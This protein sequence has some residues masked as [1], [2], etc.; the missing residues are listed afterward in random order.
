MLLMVCHHVG[1]IHLVNMVT[2]EDD[3]IIGVIAVDK[4]DILVNSIG[5]TLVPAALLVVPLIGGQ[6][7]G[8]AVGLVEA[9]GL[10]VADVFI[11]LQGLIL[12]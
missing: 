5:S 9:P 1:V 11:Q 4:I 10:T 6:D 12:G 2:G 8:A 3:H 7:L